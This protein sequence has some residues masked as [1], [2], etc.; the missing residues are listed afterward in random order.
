MGGGGGYE[1]P[2]G[3]CFSGLKVHVTLGYVRKT[4]C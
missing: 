1:S 4:V 2:V 3:G